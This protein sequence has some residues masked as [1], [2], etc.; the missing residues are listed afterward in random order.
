MYESAHADGQEHLEEAFAAWLDSKDLPTGVPTSG[1]RVLPG[2]QQVYRA[3]VAA[4]GLEALRLALQEPRPQETW[5]TTLTAVRQDTGPWHVVLDLERTGDGP[6]PV[7]FA[8]RLVGA[9]LGP[10]TSSPAGFPLRAAPVLVSRVEDAAVVLS[11]LRAPERDVP[12]V[13]AH[14][15]PGVV[16]RLAAAVAG[17]ALVV[18]LVAPAAAAFNA[19][20]G[21]GYRLRRGAW[22]TYWPGLGEPDD[23]PRRHRALSPETLQADAHRAMRV[24]AGSFRSDAL[25]KPLPVLLRD[26]VA[27]LPGF[28]SAER[29]TRRESAPDEGAQARLATAAQVEH[30]LVELVEEAER[31]LAD[32]RA[33]RAQAEHDRDGAVLEAATQAAELSATLSR[34][35]FLEKELLK[36]DVRPW[37]LTAPPVP[38]VP[39]SFDELLDAA[40]A[41]LPLLEL[42]PR[43]AASRDL[44]DHTRSLT[45]AAKAWDALLA[46]QS[47]AEAR[48]KG[49]FE[50]N[51]EQWC[52]DCP[53][54]AR[55]VSANALGMTEHDTVRT[56]PTMRE[57]RTFPVPTDVAPEGRVTM[58]AHYKVD[59]RDPAPR[60]HFHDDTRGTGMVYV[61][62]LGRH[63]PSPKTN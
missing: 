55:V 43:T 7:P 22:R 2:G 1:A 57:A 34:V 13:V 9:L 54:G 29:V 18:H 56:N 50:G 45:W 37:E 5:R 17:V 39:G 49:E 30:E 25:A 51:F 36:A 46:L 27:D 24:V 11:F 52:R 47:Y 10:A 44:D 6:P 48:V 4:D 62:Y 14:D 26:H 31:S 40:E 59:N 42:G 61:G 63:L 53:T 8:P 19:N 60:L 15:T 38:A 33:A 12:V 16:D 28:R 3:S 35:Q 41:H 58:W 32:E 20:V 23:D 21:P